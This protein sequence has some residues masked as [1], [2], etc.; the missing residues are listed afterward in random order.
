MSEAGDYDPGDWG[1]HD[2]KSAARSYDK[3]ISRSYDDAVAAGKDLKDVLPESLETQSTCP[4]IIVTDE[5]GSMGEWPKVMFSKLPY[6]A[7]EAKNEYLGED[8]EICFAAFGDAHCNENYPLQAQPFT[9]ANKKLKEVLEKLVIEGGGGGQTMETSELAALYFAHNVSMPKAKKPII[10][11]IS[12]E[13]PYDEI[14][15]DMAEKFT[16]G[17]AKKKF[18]DKQVFD[19]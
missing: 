15:A 8:C 13:Q 19:G 3:V 1:G 17:R 5:T 16:Y 9:K 10:I 4:L 14:S 18:T 7:H 2:F 6:L 12:D 11:F